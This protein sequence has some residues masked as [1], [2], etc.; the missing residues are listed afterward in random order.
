MLSSANN[1]LR[2]C[3]ECAF[4]PEKRDA[5]NRQDICIYPFLSLCIEH[6]FLVYL[7]VFYIPG[8]SCP[9]M[10][11]HKVEQKQEVAFKKDNLT[12]A[13]IL[14]GCSKQGELEVFLSFN[15]YS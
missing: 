1:L 11:E 15:A 9:Y 5:T 7:Y 4:F 10:F 2:L 8:L 13:S 12:V 6:F 14:A 3:N